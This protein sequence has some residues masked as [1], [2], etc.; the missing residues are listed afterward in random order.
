MHELLKP[1]DTYFD[2]GTELGWLTPLF[3][4]WVGAENMCL[5]EPSEVSWPSIKATWEAN[6]LTQP[7]STY[8]GFVGTSKFEGQK[9]AEIYGKRRN[10]SN[11]GGWPAVAFDGPIMPT[12]NYREIKD[13]PYHRITSIDAFVDDTGIVPQAI[14]MNVEGAEAIGLAGG[15]NTFQKYK[16]MVWVGMHLLSSALINGYKATQGDL[17]SLMRSCGYTDRFLDTSYEEWWLFN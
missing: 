10:W 4:Q 11:E 3:A 15:I 17:V 6:S 7:K 8:W 12:P 13:C 9:D 14:G 5:F 16:P 2:I 1:G